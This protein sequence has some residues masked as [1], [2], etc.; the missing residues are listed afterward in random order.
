MRRTLQPSKL[1]GLAQLTASE[2]RAHCYTPHCV[3]HSI[4]TKAQMCKVELI[5]CTQ[6]QL[7]PHALPDATS[8]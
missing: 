1:P 8:D 3:M 7:Q 4:I 2:A 6:E 5:S